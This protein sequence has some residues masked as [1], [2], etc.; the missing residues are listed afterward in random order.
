MASL[1]NIRNG[2]G[3]ALE[4]ISSLI[5]FKYIPDSIEPPTAVVGVVDTVDYDLTEARGADRYTIPVF[6]YVSRVD[7][8][9]SQETLDSYLAS[10]GATSIKATIESDTTLGGAAQSTR[11]VEAD[12]Y[13]VYTINNTDYL[14]VEFTVEVI[15]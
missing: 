13:G 5:V 12:N 7:A 4:D 3:T 15:A 8:Q 6:L 9:D 11:V 14:G 10:S 1:T 2:I